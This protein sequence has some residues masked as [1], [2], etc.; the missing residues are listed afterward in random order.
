M[1]FDNGSNRKREIIPPS[2]RIEIQIICCM[3]DGGESRRDDRCD[4][5]D[6][7]RQWE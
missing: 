3:S 6:D 2:E 7:F 4:M 1:S 5:S